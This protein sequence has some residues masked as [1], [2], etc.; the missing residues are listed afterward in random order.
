M[1]DHIL[2]AALHHTFDDC[3]RL[4]FEK[5]LGLEIQSFA[6]P[7][8]LQDDWRGLLRR[9]QQVGL[10]RLSGPLS[11]HGP[12]MDMSPGSPDELIR[13]V[14][15]RRTLQALYIAEELDVHT[16]VFHTNFIASIHNIGYRQAWIQRNIDFWGP[17][18]ERAA[19][20]NINIVLENM[21]EFDPEIVMSVLRGVESPNLRACLDVGHAHLFSDT[22]F[23]TWLATLEPYLTYMHLNNNPGDV[24]EHQ[25]LGDGALD[26]PPILDQIRRLPNQPLIVLEMNTTEDMKASFSFLNMPHNLGALRV[27][28]KLAMIL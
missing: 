22:P 12:F 17:L 2:L 24:D 11:M 20:S 16:I 21:W 25:A 27:L 9:Y 23:E 13:N 5:G 18:A 8:I 3:L 28:R 15:L 1:T 10:D 14:T 6:F 4:A 26:Y 19:H 7:E